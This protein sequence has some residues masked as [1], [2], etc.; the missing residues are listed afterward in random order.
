MSRLHTSPTLR[1]L[2]IVACL[3]GFLPIALAE[4]KTEVGA[5]LALP[6]QIAELDPCVNRVF[7]VAQLSKFVGCYRQYLKRYEPLWVQLGH[8]LEAVR[9]SQARPL[10]VQPSGVA[11]SARVQLESCLQKISATDRELLAE[12][13]ELGLISVTTESRIAAAVDDRRDRQLLALFVGRVNPAA[14]CDPDQILASIVSKSNER[15]EFLVDRDDFAR[16]AR[17][18]VLVAA[19]KSSDLFERVARLLEDLEWKPGPGG[20]LLPPEFCSVAE[21]EAQCWKQ[22]SPPVLSCLKR[23]E[24]LNWSRVISTTRL[25]SERDQIAYL[26]QALLQMCPQVDDGSLER[27]LSAA[28]VDIPPLERNA[29]DA[30]ARSHVEQKLLLLPSVGAALSELRLKR[31]LAISCDIDNKFVRK[32]EATSREIQDLNMQTRSRLAGLLTRFQSCTAAPVPPSNWGSHERNPLREVFPSLSDRVFATPE[33]RRMELSGPAIPP[34]IATDLFGVCRE[35]SEFV[36][37]WRKQI[38][39]N[40]FAR[41]SEFWKHFQENLRVD[42]AIATTVNADLVSVYCRNECGYIDDCWQS[43]QNSVALVNAFSACTSVAPGVASVKLRGLYLTYLDASTVSSPFGRLADFRRALP[44]VISVDHRSNSGIEVLLDRF[45][46]EVMPLVEARSLAWREW[47]DAYLC[48]RFS[49]EIARRLRVSSDVPESDLQVFAKQRREI[50]GR[51]AVAVRRLRDVELS[52]A[53]STRGLSDNLR[54]SGDVASVALGAKIREFGVPGSKIGACDRLLSGLRT[55]GLKLDPACCSDLSTWIEGVA[56][57]E[58]QS[59]VARLSAPF[60]DE[61]VV[62]SE[63]WDQ[64]RRADLEYARMRSWASFQCEQVAAAIRLYQTLLTAD[65]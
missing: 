35:V 21:V 47:R 50:Q 23:I 43:L 5:D 63:S 30:V 29:I 28:Y 10:V 33:S 4:I 32:V 41:V 7:D 15:V 8:A 49:D 27:A 40:D 52:I 16:D 38:S 45:W 31:C 26:G 22:V 19:R 64:M 2:L 14:L 9:S 59:V 25:L 42:A 55:G 54:H 3:T 48:L 46:Q 51:T 11:R 6:V 58:S 65:R 20:N 61:A 12:L 56:A 13:R 17:L 34:E 53:D 44:F 37:E 24:D 18:A 62:D 57:L 60:D 36:G 1:F 39:S